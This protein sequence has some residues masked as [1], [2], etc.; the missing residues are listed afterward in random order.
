MG[1]C[2]PRPSAITAPPASSPSRASPVPSTMQSS[3]AGRRTSRTPGASDIDDGVAEVPR[4]DQ[5]KRPASIRVRI[6]GVSRDEGRAKSDLSIRCLAAM[7]ATQQ[8]DGSPKNLAD[9]EEQFFQT[10]VAKTSL[11]PADLTYFGRLVAGDFHTKANLQDIRISPRHCFHSLVLAVP[12]P[13]GGS[14]RNRAR[15]SLPPQR[16]IYSFQGRVPRRQLKC[17]FDIEE[18]QY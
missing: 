6:A 8:R 1:T 14:E 13:S 5:G 18:T 4:D 2:P 17:S 11:M 15:N 10:A 16:L 9:L 3:N 7:L 12:Y